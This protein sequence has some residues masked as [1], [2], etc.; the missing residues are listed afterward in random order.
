MCTA[1]GSLASY[2]APWQ[3]WLPRMMRM[4]GVTG[5]VA[6]SPQLLLLRLLL[7]L[8]LP[9]LLL[10]QHSSMANALPS[11]HPRL[12]SVMEVPW[13]LH[14]CRA[15]A[16]GTS[17]ARAASQGR[18]AAVGRDGGHD[19]EEGSINSCDSKRPVSSSTI[20]HARS[21]CGGYPA[22]S[23]TSRFVLNVA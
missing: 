19:A 14:R 3:L 18:D 4:A 5:D 1:R 20:R 8:L 15:G 10:Q 9:V 22:P 17:P 11:P 21:N 6:S 12:P 13:G 7:L 16:N 2:L 23:R